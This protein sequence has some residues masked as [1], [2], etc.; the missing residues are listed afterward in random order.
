MRVYTFG[1]GTAEGSADLIDVL[2]GKGAGL[3]G[4]SRLGVPVPPGF[5]LPTD[6]C[7]AFYEGGETLPDGVWAA[8]E[9]GLAFVEEARG[10]RR[11][12][13]AWLGARRRRRGRRRCRRGRGGPGRR[14]TW[15]SLERRDRRRRRTYGPIARGGVRHGRAIVSGLTALSPLRARTSD[16]YPTPGIASGGR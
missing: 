10:R 7:R 13:G 6:A 1:N 11:D 15:A 3:A 8:V 16:A 2:G 12:V 4:M 9:R 5:T 14:L